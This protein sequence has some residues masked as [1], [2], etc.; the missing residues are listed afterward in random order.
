MSSLGD[1]SMTDEGLAKSTVNGRPS[2]IASTCDPRPVRHGYV[3][4]WMAVAVTVK[5][6]GDMVTTRV[7]ERGK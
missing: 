5:D 6:P 4:A 1:A 3:G 7:S 2:P